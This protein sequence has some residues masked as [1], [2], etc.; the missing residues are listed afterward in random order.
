[1][2]L[3]I[4]IVVVD[5]IPFLVFFFISVLFFLVIYKVLGVKF[6]DNNF[7]QLSEFFILG[8][9]SYRNSIGDIQAP[10]YGAEVQNQGTHLFV[11]WLCW[12]LNQF[13]VMIVLLN[14][15]ISVIG[16]TYANVT[17]QAMMHMYKQRSDLNHE[18]ILMLQIFMNFEPVEGV[19]VTSITETAA[20]QDQLADFAT[21]VKQSLAGK[22][23]QEQ[24]AVKTRIQQVEE[25]MGK[26]KD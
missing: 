24:E 12:Y 20:V 13:L 5:L 18:C 23:Q 9:S 8:I 25:K 21:A 22:K 3:M 16:E 11:I 26:M 14:F 17:G 10:E 2:V 19:T 15:L 4:N 1:M 6:S 7:T